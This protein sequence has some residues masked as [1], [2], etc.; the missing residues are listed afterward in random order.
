M[1]F[2]EVKVSPCL[3]VL[4]LGDS[5]GRESNSLKLIRGGRW[6]G[7]H[8]EPEGV[9]SQSLP[10]LV[11]GPTCFWKNDPEEGTPFPSQAL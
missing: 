3:L 10:A 4:G 2:G 9:G 7:S 6:T 5:G 11:R 1:K 8:E